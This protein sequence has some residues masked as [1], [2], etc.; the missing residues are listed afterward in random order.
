MIQFRNVMKSILIGVEFREDEEIAVGLPMDIYPA[1]Q[2]RTGF[3]MAGAGALVGASSL[4][5]VPVVSPYEITGATQASVG[6][7]ADVSISL[8]DDF[9]ADQA[10]GNENS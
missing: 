9:A 3:D 7:L 1:G 8:A 6:G 10:A 4:T 5:G 2:E